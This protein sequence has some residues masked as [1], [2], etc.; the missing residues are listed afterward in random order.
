MDR[1]AVLGVTPALRAVGIGLRPQ[2]DGDLAFLLDLYI[3][4]RREEI[5]AAGWPQETGLAFLTD[6]FRLQMSHYRTHYHDAQFL[7][8]EKAG[9]AVGRL[10]IFRG[11]RDHR[12]VD[13][14]LL[15]DMRGAGVGGALLEAVQD[16]ARGLGKTVS[17][18]VEKFNPAQHLYRRLGFREIGENGPYWLM[19]WAP[20]DSARA[21]VCQ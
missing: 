9:V 20:A 4:V 3:S 10:Y 13:I 16:E 18:H 15:P 11:P 17:V 21:A 5:E 1:V 8:V 6:Q 12:V 2:C 14:S 19:E 7:I